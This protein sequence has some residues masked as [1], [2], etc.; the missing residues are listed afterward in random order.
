MYLVWAETGP[1]F[2]SVGRMRFQAESCVIEGSIDVELKP[3][4]RPAFADTVIAVESSL[5]CDGNLRASHRTVV[6]TLERKKLDSVL[7]F[8]DQS[9]VERES[10]KTIDPALRI[11]LSGKP[12][13]A[14]EAKDDKKRTKKRLAWNEGAFVYR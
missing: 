1:S 5:G 9:E 11:A 10:G 3:V 8:S 12:P 13:L 4:H 2:T 14:A 6:V 7:D